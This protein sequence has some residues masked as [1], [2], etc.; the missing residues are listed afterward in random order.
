VSSQRTWKIEGIK[1]V[2]TLGMG[3]GAN[4]QEVEW[5]EC[6][7][8]PTFRGALSGWFLPSVR[9]PERR[10]TMRVT[11]LPSGL[12]KD[13]KISKDGRRYT[14]YYAGQYLTLEAAAKKMKGDLRP[15]S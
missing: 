14:A 12:S 9:G 3:P 4:Y 13:A 6:T 11:H 7:P 2:R 1:M 15:K 5:F 10:I 8:G